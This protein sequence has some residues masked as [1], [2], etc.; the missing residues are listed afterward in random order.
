MRTGCLRG[1]AVGAMVLVVTIGLGM[2][3]VGVVR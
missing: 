2:L 1:L 3:L